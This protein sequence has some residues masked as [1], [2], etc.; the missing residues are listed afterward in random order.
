MLCTRLMKTEKE[1]NENENKNPPANILIEIAGKPSAEREKESRRSRHTHTHQ[2]A[3]LSP[4]LIQMA[5]NGRRVWAANAKKGGLIKLLCQLNFIFILIVRIVRPVRCVCVW[6]NERQKQ[7]ANLVL[8]SARAW[9]SDRFY[10]CEWLYC[11][12][13]MFFCTSRIIGRCLCNVFFLSFGWILG[14][15]KY[16]LP[17]H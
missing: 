2:Q 13:L 4:K 14:W 12:C 8:E 5:P 16:F 9:A 17:F 3:A 11:F 6:V 1:Y 10:R 15:G 7:K